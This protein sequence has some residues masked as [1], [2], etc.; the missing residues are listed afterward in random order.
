[1]WSSFGAP[2]H[3]PVTHENMANAELTTLAF[4]VLENIKN[5]DFESLAEIAH[6]N[7]GVVFSPSA[8]ISL[9]TNRRFSAEQ[10]SQFATDNNVYVWGLNNGSGEPID[11]T[12]VDY[13]AQ[14]VYSGD[15]LNASVIGINR[16]VRSGNALENLT[17][18]FPGIKFVDF[19][20]PGDEGDSSDDLDWSSLRIGFEEYGDSL[21]LVVIVHSTWTV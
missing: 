10:I 7:F 6:P 2:S 5:G 9:S 18:E 20:I 1:M 4:G 16:I 11:M 8:T 15:F 21:W 17:N 19:H 3:E 12:P 13:F 14:F